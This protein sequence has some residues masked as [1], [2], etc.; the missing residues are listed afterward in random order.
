MRNN[1]ADTKVSEEGVG[2]D[3]LCSG[4]EIP[5]WHMEKPTVE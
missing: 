3:A 2:G 4:A 1:P 5:L